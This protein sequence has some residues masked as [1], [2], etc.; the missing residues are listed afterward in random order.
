[1]EGL[2][3]KLFKGPCCFCSPPT[4][5]HTPTMIFSC[6]V[7]CKPQ[8][9]CTNIRYCCCV[10]LPSYSCGKT[11]PWAPQQHVLHIPFLHLPS[12]SVRL[13]SQAEIK[14]GPSEELCPHLSTPQAC[15]ALQQQQLIFHFLISVLV[16]VELRSLQS[17][18]R[19]HPWL[20][21]HRSR[22]PQCS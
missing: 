17:Q 6:N 5:T 19:L 18:G 21:L 14:P 2:K 1:M 9:Q 3:G 7:L 16:S 15:A 8:G 12:L 20:S 10:L 4:H 22:L 13:T 11:T